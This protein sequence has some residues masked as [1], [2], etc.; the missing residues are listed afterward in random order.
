MEE[1]D[2]TKSERSSS[3]IWMGL[4]FVLGGIAVLLNQFDLLPFELNWWA[5]FILMPAFGFLSGAFN[6]YRANGNEFS[7]DVAFT[8]LMGLFLFLL[9]FSLLVGAAWDINWSL[10]WPVALILIGLGLI[11]NRARR[12]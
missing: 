2:R 1:S 5:L 6:R 10:L 3:G 8:A 12:E 11:F 9:S 7:M 4:V